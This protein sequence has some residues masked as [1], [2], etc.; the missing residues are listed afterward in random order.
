MGAAFLSLIFIRASAIPLGVHARRAADLP[1]SVE[2]A[3]R[4]VET[5]TPATPRYHSR[6]TLNK[7]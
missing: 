5:H 7:T 6:K 1:D 2:H 3:T 4:G